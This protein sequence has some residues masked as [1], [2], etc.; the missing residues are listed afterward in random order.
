ML[1]LSK[2]LYLPVC[3]RVHVHVRV[4][5]CVP[6]G[7]R[8]QIFPGENLKVGQIWAQLMAHSL[9]SHTP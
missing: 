5:V 3:A 7:M 4:R 6:E 1:P 8:T 2:G 9:N